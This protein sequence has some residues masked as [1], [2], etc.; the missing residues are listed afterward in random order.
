M[1][2][3]DGLPGRLAARLGGCGVPESGEQAQIIRH[4]AL[5]PS[6]LILDQ[7]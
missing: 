1:L 2:M 6:M 3:W 4:A 5:D 7:N